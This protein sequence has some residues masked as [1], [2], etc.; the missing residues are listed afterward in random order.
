[1]KISTKGRYGLR[2]LVDLAYH[3]ENDHVALKSIAE[4]QGISENYLEQVFS[5]L[6]KAGVVKSVKGAQ[7]GYSLGLP[8][9][10]LTVGKILK[11]LEGS[12][13]VMDDSEN[14]QSPKD[15]Q[16]I[17]VRMVWSQMD[18]AIEKV[19][20]HITMEDLVGQYRLQTGSGSEMYFI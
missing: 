1:M 9:K 16:G 7:G 2:A 17:L 10:D 4:R 14:S 12:L 19:V 5:A 11:V 3:S 20:E 6:R 18:E 13:T 15:I 8:A